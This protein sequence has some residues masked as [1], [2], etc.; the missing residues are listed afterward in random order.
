MTDP[1]RF[2]EGP[3]A[4]EKFWRTLA[5]EIAGSR[6]PKMKLFAS[7]WNAESTDW[8]TGLY[9]AGIL[10]AMERDPI[11]AMSAPALSFPSPDYVVMK[12]FREHYAPELLQIT[13]SPGEL[14]AT[15]TRSAGGDRIFVK[16]VNPSAHEVAL[17]ISTARRF[18]AAGSGDEAD[19]AR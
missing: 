7:E 6:N 8:R 3:A 14:D 18:S 17:E 11:V 4:A 2:A 12:L 10:N 5:A 13:G 15:V 16:V 1:D 9:A 19:R